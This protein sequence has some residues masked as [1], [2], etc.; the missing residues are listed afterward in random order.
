M[1][2]FTGDTVEEAIAAGLSSLNVSKDAVLI[3]VIDEG[4]KGFLG[5]GKKSAVVSIEVKEPVQPAV[6]SE[7]IEEEKEDTLEQTAEVQQPVKS[8]AAVELTEEEAMTELAVYLTEITKS[9]NAPAM[10]RIERSGGQIVYHLETDKKGLLIGKHGKVINALQ[11][12]SQV[13]IHRLIKSRLS[14]VVNVGDYRERREAIIHRLA[15]NTARKVRDTGQPVFLEPMPAFERKQI[16]SILSSEKDLRTY[17][18]G[19]EPHR[20]LVVEL[21]D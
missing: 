17:S 8:A 12:L 16:H 5:I 2:K 6:E 20:Y 9:L 21:A 13:Y 1:P 7:E 11:Y 19:N 10:I 4:K 18:E 15:K 3:D 14:V